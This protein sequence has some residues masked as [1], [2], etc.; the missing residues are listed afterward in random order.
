MWCKGKIY[1]LYAMQECIQSYNMMQEEKFKCQ[2]KIQQCEEDIT[3][4]NSGKKT[5]K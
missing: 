1:D 4:L 2:Q 3:K 5:F